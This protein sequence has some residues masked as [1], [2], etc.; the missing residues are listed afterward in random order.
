MS[1]SA[2]TAAA[3]ATTAVA[4]DGKVGSTRSTSG[5]EETA[6]VNS[7]VVEKVTLQPFGHLYIP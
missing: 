5:D 2:V 1:V 3:T 6:K 7:D 4:Q